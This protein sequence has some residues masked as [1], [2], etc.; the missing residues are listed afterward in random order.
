MSWRNSGEPLDSEK[1]W[2]PWCCTERKEPTLF[3]YNNFRFGTIMPQSSVLHV[4]S[5]IS[6]FK[7]G[8]CQFC[9]IS[10]SQKLKQRSTLWDEEFFTCDFNFAARYSNVLQLTDNTQVLQ[11]ILWDPLWLIFIN[12]TRMCQKWGEDAVDTRTRRLPD[13]EKLFATL[14]L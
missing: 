12:L 11:Q 10:V 7:Y 1:H 9:F 8:F 4:C 13:L 5:V 14:I 6:T 2:Q 3:I